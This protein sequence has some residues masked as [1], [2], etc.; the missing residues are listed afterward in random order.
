M[1]NPQVRV[2]NGHD[3][4]VLPG[5]FQPVWTCST[6]GQC[7]DFWNFP[8]SVQRGSINEKSLFSSAC[9]LLGGAIL[10]AQSVQQVRAGA[11]NDLKDSIER[12]AKLRGKIEQE[13]TFWPKLLLSLNAM[14]ETKGQR[15]TAGCAIAGQP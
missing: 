4:T 11:R 7:Q 2:G 5:K 12:L 15:L 10:T 13:K 9:L 8:S 1:E 14:Q 3:Q 6:I